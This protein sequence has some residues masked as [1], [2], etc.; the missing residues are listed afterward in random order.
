VGASELNSTR[1]AARGIRGAV[2]TLA[3]AASAVA[4]AQE[5]PLAPT[6]ADVPTSPLAEAAARG[7]LQAVRTL[8]AE[9]NLDANASSRD[10]TPA[11]HWVVRVGDRDTAER[12]AAAGADV[13]AANRYG[14][15]PLHLAIAAGDTEMTR[16]LLD[17]G[18]DA[19]TPDRS[20]EPPLLLAA[21]V[22]VLGVAQALLEHGAAVDARDRNF[23]QTPLMAAVREGHLELAE[24]LIDAGADVNA[25]STGEAPPR[26]VPP[27]ESPEGL[28]RG[29]G[30]IRAGWP[31]GRGKR[32]PAAGAK[33]PLLYATREGQLEVARLLIERGANVELADG[34]GITPL[35]NVIV[36]A[37]IFRVN[38]T[39]ESDHLKIAN[40]L[41][42][43]GANVN[44]VD[45]YGQTP[46]WAT[47]DLRNLELGRDGNDRDVRDEAFALI[48]RLL[49]SGAEP[50][51]RTREFPHER[52]YLVVIVGSVAWVDLTGQTPFLRAAA[53]GDLQVMRL[54]L[55]H[56]ADPNIAT[57]AGT[58]PLMVAAG[59]NWAFAETYDE[60][61][62]ALLAAV[63][64][65]HELGNDLNAVNS[66]GV[67]AI[68]GAA[69]RGAN[70]VIEYLAAHGARLDLA[71]KQGRTPIDWANGVFLAT[72][73]PVRK[74][75][76]IALLER[77]QQQQ[78]AAVAAAP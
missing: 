45:W 77:L 29:L 69:N 54:L 27:S 49:R 25:Q 15:V 16:W 51:A 9:G 52:R 22:G 73:P 31:E 11:L 64:L 28:S 23:G 8:L 55:E 43:S 34:N 67:A 47:V 48:E 61:P 78:H 1:A 68:H 57:Y 26:F 6:A 41:L 50:N 76:T 60:G 24:A 2:L 7:D 56:G 66:M 46:L 21:R 44:A 13:N 14:V 42:D 63:K 38:R 30:I 75:E 10:G 19:G 74:A 39:G 65:T 70:D 17:A 36:N 20:G 37:S 33:T 40:L 58:T 18:A 12:L 53:A 32:F 5:V 72:H 62:E 3:I 35:I 4:V 71:D 59:V